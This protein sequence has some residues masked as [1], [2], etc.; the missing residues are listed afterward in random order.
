M[1]EGVNQA[2][3]SE[4]HFEMWY[5]GVANGSSNFDQI[6]ESMIIGPWSKSWRVGSRINLLFSSSK[7]LRVDILEGEE[8]E[9]SYFA[10]ESWLEE[11]ED[12][13]EEEELAEE[14]TLLRER[15]GLVES[16]GMVGKGVLNKNVYRPNFIIAI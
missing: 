3:S 11:D 12:D 16:E 13:E 9:P 8:E 4:G 15:L 7:I 14:L 5:Q 10:E 6:K 2:K 1:G